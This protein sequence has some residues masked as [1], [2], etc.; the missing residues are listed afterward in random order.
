[1]WMA[2]LFLECF[3]SASRALGVC[4]QM[5]TETLLS[6][7]RSHIWAEQYASQQSAGASARRRFPEMEERWLLCSV[8]YLCAVVCRIPPVLT[9]LTV[10]ARVTDVT[11]AGTVAVTDR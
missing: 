8:D 2:R 9:S 11:V 10:I 5:S 1:M 3:W 6:C 4:Q 7:M